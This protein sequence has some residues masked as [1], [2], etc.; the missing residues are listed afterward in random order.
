MSGPGPEH[1]GLAD[2]RDHGRAWEV[3][4]DC[5]AQW[6]DQGE[7]VSEGDGSCFELALGEEPRGADGFGEPGAPDVCIECYSTRPEPHAK[8]CPWGSR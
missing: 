2:V 3:C 4:N 8:G 5:G 7:Q 1:T 6:D